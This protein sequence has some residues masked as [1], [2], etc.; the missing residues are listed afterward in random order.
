MKIRRALLLSHRWL[1][2]ASAAILAVTGTTGAA[3]LYS[4]AGVVRRV[5]GK[6]HEELALGGIG[7]WL[8]VVATIVAVP[9]EVIGIALWWKR[10][11]LS[12]RFNAGWRRMWTD[13]HHPVGVLGV[14]IM[15]VLAVSGLGMAFVAPSENPTLRRLL[16]ALHTAAPYPWAVRLLYLSATL[17]F[18]V[19]AVSGV[20][21]WWKSR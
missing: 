9:V 11:A 4:R 5:A 20:V 12:V 3:L 19:Q 14:T 15:L 2:L 21:M 18:A 17:G 10:K 13:L 1:G 8:V 6:L 7:W 16:V